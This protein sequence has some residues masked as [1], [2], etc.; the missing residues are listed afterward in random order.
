M[1]RGKSDGMKPGCLGIYGIRA[2]RYFGGYVN[3]A[4]LVVVL[5]MGGGIVR[6]K[7]LSVDSE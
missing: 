4:R 7:Y 1:A 3:F 5:G 2:K 6:A